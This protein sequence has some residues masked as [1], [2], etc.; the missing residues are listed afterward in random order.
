MGFRPSLFTDELD[1]DLNG[2]QNFRPPVAPEVLFLVCRYF[3]LT[4][5]LLEPKEWFLGGTGGAGS[6]P[7]DIAENLLVSMI[8]GRSACMATSLFLTGSGGGIRGA[9]GLTWLASRSRFLSSGETVFEI[10]SSSH[11]AI[12]SEFDA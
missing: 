8:G 12:L 2:L 4:M 6:Q 7:S 1:F 11:P 5:P 9:V 3:F 10:K